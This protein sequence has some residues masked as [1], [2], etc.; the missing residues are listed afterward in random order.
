[1][2][3]IPPAQKLAQ[4]TPTPWKHGPVFMTGG[5]A[6][7]CN[8]DSRPGKWQ[9]RVDDK[10]GVFTADDAALIVRCVNSH[11]ALVEA[12]RYTIAVLSIHQYPTIEECMAIAQANVALKA[13]TKAGE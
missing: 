9:R 3:D 8:D 13:A 1:M 2:T 12:L 7:F 5:R 6:I 4:H 11:D 10:T